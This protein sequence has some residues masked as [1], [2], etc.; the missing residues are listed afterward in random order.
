MGSP[1]PS[2]NTR[3]S[4][5][6]SVFCNVLKT[7]KPGAWSRESLE[8]HVLRWS[9]SLFLRYNGVEVEVFFA[10]PTPTLNLIIL[11]VNCLKMKVNKL[12]QIPNILSYGVSVIN[13]KSST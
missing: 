6:I 2:V 11:Y 9:R 10:T 5:C 12:H 13:F 7:L 4:L 3:C 8:S 1:F